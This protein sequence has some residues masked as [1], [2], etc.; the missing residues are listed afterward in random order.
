[1]VSKVTKGYHQTSGFVLTCQDF[2][3]LVGIVRGFFE[4]DRILG[5]LV[6]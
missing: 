3:A 2:Q 6:K 4:N 1:M 5:D